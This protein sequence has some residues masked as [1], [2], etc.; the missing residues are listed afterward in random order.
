MIRILKNS[1]L[2]V[3]V[4]LPMFC[5]AQNDFGVWTGVDVRVPII[6]KLDAGLQLE[7]RFTNNVSTVDQSF[8]SPYLKFNLHKHIGL[9]VAYRFG[10]RPTT[11][12]LGGE[13][14]H[15]I[16][17][18]A[19]FKDLLDLFMDK[20]RLELDARIRLTHA[21][22]AGDLNNDYFRT[23]V[24]LGYN[25]PKTKLK[26]HVAAEF[27]LHF[28][29][30]MTYTSTSLTAN[31]RFN[32]YR[33]RLGLEYPINK[34]HKLNVYYLVQPKIES[35]DTDFILGLGYKYKVKWKKKGGTGTPK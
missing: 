20:S 31:H 30:Q 6:K 1:L 2:V 3:G 16:G 32:K 28:N 22:D 9:G 23:R 21:T 29:D 34:R 24:K 35:V 8:V 15:R 18:D 14:Y 27:F 13:T 25:I 17:L 11:G 19:N 26:P 5:S 33:L 7:S 10:N 4:A 12:L